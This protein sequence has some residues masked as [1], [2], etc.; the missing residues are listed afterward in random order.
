MNEECIT[1]EVLK[2]LGRRG[3]SVARGGAPGAKAAGAGVDVKEVGERL[4]MLR[5]E[6]HL[7]QE[8]L[9]GE[10]LVSKKLLS[11]IEGGKR[12]L[13]GPI[14][15]ALECLFGVNRQWLLTGEGEKG[16][17]GFSA[18]AADGVADFVRSYNRLSPE[19]RKKLMNIL[20]VFLLTENKV[21]F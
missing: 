5:K 11:E 7:S 12:M 3:G 17:S 1:A 8:Q 10:L 14:V 19:G 20:R 13:C 15:V 6:F 9:A 21:V 16:G 4:K 2:G 18:H